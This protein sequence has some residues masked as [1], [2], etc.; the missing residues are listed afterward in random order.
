MDRLKFF[1]DLIIVLIGL[2]VAFF[3]FT[4]VKDKEVVP[5]PVETGNNIDVGGTTPT[6]TSLTSEKGISIFVTL[7]NNGSGIT[8]PLHIKGR[9]P[10][11]WFF[12]ANMPV[13][14]TNWDGLIIAEGHVNAVGEWM[15]ADYVPFEGDI[16]FTS[17]ECLADYCKRGSLILRK[18]N[19]SGEPQFDDS[20]EDVVKF[21]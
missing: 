2:F 21:K 16:T 14:L 4:K 19:P 12:E 1:R 9:A 5:A 6:E 20:V 18:D 11:N 7:P 17:G 15:T 3:I 8:S 10:G 13:T